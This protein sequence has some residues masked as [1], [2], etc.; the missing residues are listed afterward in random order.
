M[1]NDLRNLL[2]ESSESAPYDEFD[3]SA[4]LRAGRSRTRCR[5]ATVIG[6]AGL[7]AAAVVGSTIALGGLVSDG[8]APTSPSGDTSDPVGP[9]LHLEDATTTKLTPIFRSVDTQARA[10][11]FRFVDGVTE[12]GRAIVRD[13]TS[14]PERS[15]LKLVDLATEAETTLPDVPGAVGPVLEAS[16]Q[17]IVYSADVVSY[18]Q[19]ASR[20]MEARALVL[21]RAT[22]TWQRLRWPGLPTGSVLGRDIGPDGRLYV[23]INP[24]ALDLQ[25]PPPDGLT[26]EL[27]SVSLTDPADV[28]DEDLVVGNFAIDDNRLVWSDRSQG[29][30]NKLTVRDLQTGED[31]SFDPHSGSCVQ[32]YLGLDADHI[33]MSQDCVAQDGV[34]EDRV[35]VVTLTGEPVVTIQDVLIQGLVDDGGHLLIAAEGPGAKGVYS[36]DL[37]TGDFVRLSTSVALMGQI[38]MLG[39][40]VEGYVVWAEGLKG[41]SLGSV[42]SVARVP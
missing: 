25:A 16:A 11:D 8:T 34:T 37:S 32:E 27:W 21:D 41:S 13:T 30:S 1:V 31:T 12:D 23:A 22:E 35:Q 3:T 2:S 24:G 15:L 36:Y 18:G 33:V 14:D 29:F 7:A 17:R 42:Q 6:A 19:G 9:V 38:M 39:P 5:R 4:I 40:V 20:K 28:R 10:T 26:G